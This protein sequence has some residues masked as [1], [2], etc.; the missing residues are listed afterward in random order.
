MTFKIAGCAGHGLNTPGKRSPN[1]EHEWSFNNEVI[2]AFEEALKQYENV[3]FLR[4]DDRSGRTDVALQT[5]T[6]K[7]NTWGADIY[8]SFHHNAN[9]GVW[10]NG[11]GTELF[12]WGSGKSQ[13][14][15]QI[16][17]PKVLNAYGLT[18]RGVKN[19]SDLWIIRKT[20]MPAILLEGCF[21]DSTIDIVKLRD[22]NV[23]RNAGYAV[24]Q[25]VAEYA[26]LKKK[27]GASQPTPAPQPATPNP[28]TSNLYR[29]RKTWIDVK[30]QVGAF[31]NLQNATDVAKQYAGYNVYDS[32]G[33][34]VYPI[35]SQPTPQPTQM[36]RVRLSWQDSKSQIGA[37]SNIDNAKS[38]A[39]EH[40][41]EGYKVFDNSGKV[42][43]TSV[44][45]QPIPTPEPPKVEEPT[46]TPVDIHIG[47]HD[48]LGV[49][50][51]ALEKM[52][53]FVKE[54]NPNVQDIEEITKQFIEVGNKYGIRGDIAF[55]QSI[56]ETGWFKFDGGTA[57]TPDQHNYCGMG[58]TSKG[59][60]GNEFGNVKDGV[61]SQIQHLFA[62]CSQLPLPEDNILD[63]RFK[64][65][66]RGIVPHWEDLNNH[67]AMNATYGQQILAMYEQ[68]VNYEYV[69][70]IP[71]PPVQEIPKKDVPAD[72]TDK[73][74]NMWMKLI[75][76]IF[77][78]L[79]EFF[80]KNK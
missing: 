72:N 47:H 67:W 35:A 73:Q 52:V 76:Y 22:H 16:V 44:V 71:E 56:I 8:I 38:L 66:T 9:G 39:D 37:F 28:T 29:I 54:K 7:A 4:T 51:V 61:T 74:M 24:A 63:P 48:I 41:N 1:G 34:Q 77:T 33:N 80:G 36:Y 14:L 65:V 25:G 13:Q 53:A 69:P 62:Y 19:G 68:L 3:E 42:V 43:Y 17:Y 26:G 79:A 10:F 23:L 75:D 2:L 20:N 46:P 18:S 57:V 21:M 11:G 59:M 31:A 70:P 50:I 78:K 15:G 60:K 40:V 5:R 30:S 32:N 49:S 58:V 64:Y 45:V 27:A 55:C 6:D 12:T